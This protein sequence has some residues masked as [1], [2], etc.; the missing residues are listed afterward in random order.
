MSETILPIFPLPNM[1]FFPGMRLPLHIFEPRYRQMLEEALAG[2]KRIGLVLLREGWEKDYYGSPETYRIGSHGRV[3]NLARLP[4][5]R[6]NLTLEEAVRFEIIDFVRHTPYRMARVRLLP[7][8]P[9][10]PPAAG[11]RQMEQLVR[12]YASLSR[13]VG[14]DPAPEFYPDRPQEFEMHVNA[15]AMS[16]RVHPALRQDLLEAPGPGERAR[17]LETLLARLV[18]R[19]TAQKRFDSLKPKSGDVN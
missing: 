13:I 17:R 5:G 12:L 11:A 18:E 15:L 8:E 2:E 4:D 3:D 7:E 19:L 14:Q 6:F 10:P 16:L 9:P 1:V